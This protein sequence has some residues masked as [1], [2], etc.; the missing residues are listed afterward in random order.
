MTKPAP[1]TAAECNRL[2]RW[3]R[4]MLLFYGVAIA[5]LALAAALM[6]L[7][8]EL[9]WVRRAAMALL[10]ALIGAATFVQFRERCPR[11]GWRLGSQGRLFL[12]AEC[13]G[14]GVEFAGQN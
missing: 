8:G 1:L 12:P 9:A 4:R 13:P 2:W 6:L 14:C 10:L 11:C 7:F 3:Q 5:L